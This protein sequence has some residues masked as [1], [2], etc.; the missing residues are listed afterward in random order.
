MDTRLS[1]ATGQHSIWGAIR[2]KIMWI[3]L[4][5]ET[6]KSVRFS[7]IRTDLTKSEQI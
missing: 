1:E 7:Y 5:E 3:H 4:A 6:A 2:K